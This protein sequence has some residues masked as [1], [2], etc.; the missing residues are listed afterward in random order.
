MD[1]YLYSYK[2]ELKNRDVH[3]IGIVSMFIGTK[4]EE[5]WPLK[6]KTVYEKIGHKKFSEHSIRELETQMLTLSKFKVDK[7]SVYDF[8]ELMT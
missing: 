2:N 4:Y 7:F 8:V 3:L 5:I 6:L 1:Q